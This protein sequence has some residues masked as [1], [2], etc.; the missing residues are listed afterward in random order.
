M[1]ASRAC[2]IF[3]PA[4]IV[5]LSRRSPARPATSISERVDIEGLAVTLV[6][7]AGWRETHDV[8][9]REGVARSEQARGVADLLILVLD[10]SEPIHREDEAL[11]AQTAD[12]PRIVVANKS[13][14]PA[15]APSSR[16][17]GSPIVEVSAKTGAGLDDLR[18]A[19]LCA[20][21]GRESLRD[22]SAISNTRHIALLEQ[23]RAN[24]V[25]AARGGRL[26]RARR[27]SS[28]S[29]ICR[30]PGPGSMKSWARARATTC[31][32]TFSSGSVSGNEHALTSS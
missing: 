3:S 1:S 4:P 24:L 11:L 28:S 6:D 2:S 32:S 17:G 19:I 15:S 20:L 10:R 16:L 22:T 18:R 5:R 23:A 29:P 25:A 26:R 7:T 8:V 30:P 9:E 13:D 14:L 31:C 27:R 12:R 21:T